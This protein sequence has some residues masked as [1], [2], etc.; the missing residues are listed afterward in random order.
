MR[1]FY[2]LVW[3]LQVEAGRS[4][5]RLMA[6]LLVQAGLF[7]ELCAQPDGPVSAAAALCLDDMVGATLFLNRALE[8]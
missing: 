6:E 4:D 1:S 8:I 5:G 7:L 2:S 3:L